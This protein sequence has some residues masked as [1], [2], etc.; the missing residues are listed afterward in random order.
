M[1]EQ[2]QQLLEDL[3]A[4]VQSDRVPVYQGISGMP[5]KRPVKDF[6]IERLAQH[7]ATKGELSP[8]GTHKQSQGQ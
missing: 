4:Y 6:I 7:F 5:Y 3:M 1:L 8:H 2:E